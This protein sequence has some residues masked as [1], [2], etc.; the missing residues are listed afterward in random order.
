MTMKGCS[1][2]CKC[3]F[4]DLFYRQLL[5]FIGF[6]A[7]VS[8]LGGCGENL[9][10]P[11]RITA[12]RPSGEAVGR[13]S[14][15]VPAASEV[16]RGTTSNAAQSKQM[17]S[18]KEARLEELREQIEGGAN[19]ATAEILYAAL[20]DREPEVRDDAAKWLHLLVE[21]DEEAREKVEQLQSKEY[22][23]D[24]WQRADD[25]LAPS[26]EPMENEVPLE[27]RGEG[28]E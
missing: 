5:P 3:F 6:L 7:V 1:K 18:Y 8:V 26:E 12:D 19:P 24:V 15:N 2:A 9:S 27:G 21:Q 10:A 11:N 25:L 20:S 22:S 13:E 14:T 16:F 23:R 28:N 17:V 4:Q